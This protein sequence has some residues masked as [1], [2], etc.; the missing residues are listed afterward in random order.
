MTIGESRAPVQPGE[1]A[2]DFTLPAVEREGTVSLADYRGR[3]PVLLALFRGL[4]CP[5]CRRAI[6]QLGITRDKLRGMGVETLG[7]VA[8]KTE[9]ARL[10][11]RHRP[12]RLPLAADAE[13]ATHRAY[14]L[15]KP[16]VTP[17]LLQ[18]M[19]TVRAN[20]TGDLPEPMPLAE[21]AQAI[22][23]LDGFE[24]TA[25]DRE[26]MERQFPQLKGQFLVDR[27]GIVRWANIECA[28]EGI[29]GLGQFPAEEA[30]LAAA[31]SLH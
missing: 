19:K 11:F 13:L 18:A 30:I 10:Y 15:P 23:R 3:A 8:T 17:D 31:K 5:F 16:P 27:D 4:Y 22:D 6:A 1:P 14:G 28:R 9:N 25:T 24:P 20:P 29:A 2:P 21:A 12:T 7:V 26:D